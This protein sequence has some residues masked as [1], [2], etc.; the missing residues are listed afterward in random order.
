MIG[1]P[2]YLGWPS[3][4]SDPTAQY[5]KYKP[6]GP[7]TSVSFKY[8]FLCVFSTLMFFFHKE[9]IVLLKGEKIL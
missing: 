2:G 3:S 5:F 7:D 6:P 9:Y 1:F 8:V 4:S